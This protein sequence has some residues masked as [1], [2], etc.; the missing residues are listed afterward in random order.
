MPMRRLR[1]ARPRLGHVERSDE[2]VEHTHTVGAER[3]DHGGHSRRERDAIGRPA[4]DGIRQ[5]RS[6]RVIALGI[7]LAPAASK[8]LSGKA[9]RHAVHDLGAHAPAAP[10]HAQQCVKVLERRL[11]MQ[12]SRHRTSRT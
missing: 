12:G 3:T 8:L 1:P 6:T 9:K 2:V 4:R 7:R 11:G 5:R 10:A